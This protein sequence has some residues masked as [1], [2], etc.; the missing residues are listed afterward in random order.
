[1]CAPSGNSDFCFFSTV[2]VLRHLGKQNSTRY[3]PLEQTLSVYC[4]I[5]V[6]DRYAK[7]KL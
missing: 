6:D 4:H 7:Q 5:S 3:F 1:M 2:N